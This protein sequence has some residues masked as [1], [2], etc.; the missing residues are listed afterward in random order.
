[1]AQM[2]C[3]CYKK[4][5]NELNECKKSLSVFC[6]RELRRGPK[7]RLFDIAAFC[8]S[9]FCSNAKISAKYRLF[10]CRLF[11]VSVF[12]SFDRRVFALGF[13]PDT[14]LERRLLW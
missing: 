9:A 11:D 10:D 3:K 2:K 13:L 14:V 6:L 7:Y 1:M 12:S 5:A 8:I 4:V